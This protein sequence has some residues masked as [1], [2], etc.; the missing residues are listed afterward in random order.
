ME[1]GAVV[2]SRSPESGG[3]P[4]PETNILKPGTKVRVVGNNRTKQD[5]IN[6][7]G[8]VIKTN[9]LGGWHEIGERESRYGMTLRAQ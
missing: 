4:V 2:H 1:E 8:T 7:T 5:F 6:L 3:C 9:G